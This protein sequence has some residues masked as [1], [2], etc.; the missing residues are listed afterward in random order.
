MCVGLL[1][2][3]LL[4]GLGLLRRFC[5]CFFVVKKSDCVVYLVIVL[6]IS[7][8]AIVVKCLCLKPCWCG[9]MNVLLVMCGRM[10]FIV[11]LQWVRVVLWAC[12]TCL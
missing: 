8:S 3:M 11:F 1:C 5:C 4:R 7:C 6:F 12:T 9:G 2:G 10:I